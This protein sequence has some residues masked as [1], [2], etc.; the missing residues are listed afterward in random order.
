MWLFE[1][2]IWGFVVILTLL[3]IAAAVVLH[4]GEK[5]ARRIRSEWPEARATMRELWK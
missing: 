3:A 5:L 1:A 2:G 4:Y